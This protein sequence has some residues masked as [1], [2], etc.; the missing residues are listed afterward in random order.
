MVLE[1]VQNNVANYIDFTIFANTHL[2]KH[3]TVDIFQT[4]IAKTIYFSNMMLGNVVK[5][6]VSTALFSNMEPGAPKSSQERPGAPR[7]APKSHI[8]QN[9]QKLK[10]LLNY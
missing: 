3:L 9:D 5:P 4:N 8:L 7:G 6:L 1:H 2:L 10:L